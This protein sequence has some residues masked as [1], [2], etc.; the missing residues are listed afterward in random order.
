MKRIRVTGNRRISGLAL[1]SVLLGGAFTPRASEAQSSAPRL[2]EAIDVAETHGDCV[3]AVKAFEEIAKVSDRS[4]A[5]R[6]LLYAGRCY[7]R[8]GRMQA[9]EV[10]QR[11]LDRFPEQRRYADEARGRL[12]RLTGRMPNG[13]GL[14]ALLFARAIDVPGQPYCV[15]ITSGGRE[16]YV[17]HDRD[18]AVTVIDTEIGRASCR[19]RV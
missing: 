18:Q 4:L 10:Y 9:A 3:S 1:A 12:S 5:A 15:A 19:E 11:L 17:T 2:Q 7:E 6:A 8:L 16:A 14:P 13:G